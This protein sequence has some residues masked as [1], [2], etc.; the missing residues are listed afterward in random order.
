MHQLQ[1]VAL[2]EPVGLKVGVGCLR[3]AGAGD[4]DD[5]SFWI[6]ECRSV[7][8]KVRAEAS[9]NEVAIMSLFRGALAGDEGSPQRGQRGIG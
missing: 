1:P 2:T 4:G 7:C 9:A 3:R 6:G 5:V 8:L